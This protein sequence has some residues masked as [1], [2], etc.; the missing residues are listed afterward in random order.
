MHFLDAIPEDHVLGLAPLGDELHI[1]FHLSPQVRLV[2]FDAQVLVGLNQ[3]DPDWGRQEILL[4]LVSV[5]AL[6]NCFNVLMDG[7]I[8]TYPVLI[9]LRDQVCL[10]EK[11][12]RLSFSVNHLQHW[13]KLFPLLNG[14]DDRVAPFLVMKDL[15]PVLLFDNEPFCSEH[16]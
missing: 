1:V 14:R 2:E 15:E 8:G 3:G 11:R 16:F 9:H 6:L 4:L 10:T 5:I 12:G 7:G 13:D